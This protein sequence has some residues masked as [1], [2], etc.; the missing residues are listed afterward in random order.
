MRIAEWYND[1]NARAHPSEKGLIA[2]EMAMIE[3]QMHPLIESIK[4]S[5]FS[6]RHIY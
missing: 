1:T 2:A 6:K 4:W 3:E 5:V